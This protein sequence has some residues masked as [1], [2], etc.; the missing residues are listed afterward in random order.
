M[1]YGTSKKVWFKEC[2][3]MLLMMSLVLLMI[4]DV[5]DVIDDVTGVTDKSRSEC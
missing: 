2:L 3:I 5:T 1:Y 4:D